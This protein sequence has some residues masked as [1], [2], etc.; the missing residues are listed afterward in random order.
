MKSKKFFV[1]ISVFIM[2]ICCVGAISAASD[3]VMNNTVSEMDSFEE[4]VSVST[5]EQ[6]IGVDSTGVALDAEN[7]N[8]D[9]TNDEKIDVFEDDSTLT[10]NQLDEQ[11]SYTALSEFYTVK[12]EEAYIFSPY[13]QGTIY[14]TIT[15]PSYNLLNYGFKIFLYD[16]DEN[17]VYTSGSFVGRSTYFSLN[18]PAKTLLPGIY[19]LYVVNDQDNKI[20]A[21]SV[22]GVDGDAIITA[23][24]YNDIYM[25]NTKMTA[26]ITDKVTGKPLTSLLVTATFTNGKTKVTKDYLPNSNGQISFIPP[27]GVGTWTVTLVSGYSGI[28][29]LVVKTATVKKSTVSIKTYKVT[30]YKGFKTTLK[31]VVKSNGKKVNEGTVTFKSTEKHTMQMSKKV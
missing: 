20:M 12:L 1:I 10:K 5:D 25:S 23:T 19:D 28:T 16:I 8:E 2:F 22:L 26:R 18:I 11:L 3:D 6:A 15:P 9:I 24:D 13:S 4:T 29:G 17:I 21:E 14:G 30:E 31:A 27:V 7:S